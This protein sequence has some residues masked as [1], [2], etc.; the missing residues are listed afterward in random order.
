LLPVE[1]SVNVMDRNLDSCLFHRIA[2]PK[3]RDAVFAR[4]LDPVGGVGCLPVDRPG[5]ACETV[6]T[7]LQGAKAWSSSS[8]ADAAPG[9]SWCGQLCLCSLVERV[10]RCLAQH[11]LPPPAICPSSCRGLVSARPLSPFGRFSTG[12]GGDL[13]RSTTCGV[14]SLFTHNRSLSYSA[15]AET[16]FLSSNRRQKT[17]ANF[18]CDNSY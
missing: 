2:S 12:S 4:P 13:I 3:N 6:A 17:R 14:D 8:G 7:Q 1:V 16:K 15:P 10:R 5:R 18:G 11:S 9:W